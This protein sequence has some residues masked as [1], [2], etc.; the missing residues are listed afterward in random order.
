MPSPRKL[1][2]GLAALVLAASLAACAGQQTTRTGFLDPAGPA[3]AADR[4]GALTFTAAPA[5][6]ARYEAVFIEPVVFRAGPATPAAPDPAVER[7]LAEAYRTTLA[8]AFAARHYRVLDALPAA[9]V[10]TLRVRA[11]ITGHERANV[12]LNLATTLLLAPVTAGG[13]ASE[14]EVVDAAT[15]ER[16]VALATHSNG[17]PFLGGPHN[18][19]R[20]HGHARAALARHA[21]DLAERLPRR[22]MNWADRS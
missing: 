4:E 5:V 22:P 19:F 15:G 6:L 7:D 17:T 10:R 12:A 9:P 2:R 18:Y 8:E 16:L 21:R 1:T 13:A 11:A 3:L 20:Q 14:A